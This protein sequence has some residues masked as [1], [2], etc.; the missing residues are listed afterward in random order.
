MVSYIILQSS[1]SSYP[2][3]FYDMVYLLHNLGSEVSPRASIHFS[4]DKTMSSYACGITNTLEP[5]N[6]N[7]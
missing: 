2:L 1:F 7:D 4:K 3:L 5:F 6:A